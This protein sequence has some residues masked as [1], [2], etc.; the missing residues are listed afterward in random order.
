[1]LRNFSFAEEKDYGWNTNNGIVTS[2]P[3]IEAIRND[4]FQHKKE[5]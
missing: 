2:Q 1:M 3:T 5:I 4:L